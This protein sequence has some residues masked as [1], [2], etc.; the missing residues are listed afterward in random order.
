METLII[1]KRRELPRG[2]RILWDI[3]TVLLWLGFF[4]L[5]KP[6][7]IVFYKIIT[8]EVPAEEISDWIFENISSVTF[9]HAAFLLIATPVI[10]FILS[11]LSR[12]KAP[13]EHII[14]APKDYANYF[15]LNEASVQECADS[16]L[17]TVYFDEHGQIIRLDNQIA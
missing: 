10:L 2:K 16:Q 12:H 5:W 6:L 14:Y 8:L 17:I 9:E 11:R 3:I 7:L 15:N 13:S 1:N 4:Y